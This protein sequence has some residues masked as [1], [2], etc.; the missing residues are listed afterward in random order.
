M[1]INYII[2]AFIGISAGIIVSAGLFAFI[3]VIGIIPRLMQ[4]TNTQDFV[5]V[6][7]DAATLGGLF[8]AVCIMFEV[9]IPIGV[10]GSSIF[11]IFAGIFVGSLAVS[12]A[13]VLNVIPILTR[14]L[15]LNV[16]M[17]YFIVALAL[18]KMVGSL[19]YFIVPGF[20]IFN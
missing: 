20:T 4:K 7:E 10:V 14:R 9:R 15:R 11:G 1:W 19:I 18:G 6:Y 2:L 17:A 16:G 5:N 13:E 12:L 8:G 3:S